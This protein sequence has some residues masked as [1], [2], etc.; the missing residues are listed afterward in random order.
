MRTSRL[1]ATLAGILVLGVTGAAE[2]SPP[3]RIAR[4]VAE[5]GS[6]RFAD[7]DQATRDLDAIGEPALAALRQ[8]ARGSDAE[9][10]RRAEELI[11]RIAKRV[12][13]AKLLEAKRVRLVFKDKPLADAIAELSRQTG[14]QVQL[15][16][17][18]SKLANRKITLDTG[19][20]TP[21]QAF[22]QFCE[23]AGLTER[24]P[25]VIKKPEPPTTD[26]KAREEVLLKRQLVAIALIEQSQANF[27]PQPAGPVTL[28]DGKPER[29]PTH[30]AGAVRVQAL[31]PSFKGPNQPAALGQPGLNLEITPHPAVQ[32]HRIVDVRIEHAVDEHGQLLSQP[33][34]TT[35]PTG[36]NDMIFNQ[37]G[38]RVVIWSDSG[39]MPVVNTRQTAVRLKPGK[40]PS[41]MLK[42]VRGIV[43]AQV[44][45]PSEPLIRVDDILR[46]AG[47][48]VKGDKGGSIKV[49][50]VEQGKD[51][52]VYL[53][54]VL[55][56]PAD[57]IAM[58]FGPMAGR[59][60]VF[61]AANGKMV[62]EVDNGL[63]KYFALL[64][65]QGKPYKIVN[66]EIIPSGLG[67]K[68]ELRMTFGPAKGQSEPA[69][70]IFS[71]PRTVTIDVPFTL[72]DVPLS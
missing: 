17:D 36:G 68:Q 65:K 23:K 51:G 64:D 56:R 60:A 24:V 6:A 41:K 20:V 70:L 52:L 58:P 26:A 53:H 35:Q 4:L 25:P 33:P 16:G 54:I 63:G 59:V 8:A 22:E 10:C 71:S 37:L 12:E 28:Y 13:T 69:R 19:E 67:F 40:M 46:A 34:A 2:K 61:L 14:L 72:K 66:T 1:L 5:L 44:Q 57:A 38:G 27:G 39:E 48:G 42:E 30:V 49:L 29:V 32:W 43:A 50:K 21:W 47:R 45:T 62:Q 55:D 9:V 11:E 15:G 3:D 7:R 31:P 18:K